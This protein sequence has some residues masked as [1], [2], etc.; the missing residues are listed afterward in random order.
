MSEQFGHWLP[1]TSSIDFCEP[2]YL[3]NH[4][5][6]EPFNVVSSIFIAMLGLCGLLYSNPTQEAMF[7]V[8]FLVV[9]AVGLGSVLLHTT[10]QVSFLYISFPVI[11]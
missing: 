7:S 2:D 8:Q 3:L 1:H 11:I 4:Y 6:A 5:V 9:I 10:L